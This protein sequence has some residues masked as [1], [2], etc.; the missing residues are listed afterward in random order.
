MTQPPTGAAAPWHDCPCG[1]VHPKGCHAHT[2]RDDT[3]RPCGAPA[4]TGLTV[5]YRH[6]GATPTAK[7]KAARAKT[8]IAANREVARLGMK[9]TTHP[10]E[11][12]IDLVHWTAGEVAYWRGIVVELEQQGGHEALTWG[13]TRVKEGGDD[14]GTTQEAKPHIAYLMLTQASDR[15]ASYSTA[16]LKAGVQERSIRLAEAQGVAVAGIQRAILER[17]FA[18]VLQMLRSHGIDDAEIITA[19]EQAWVEAMGVIVPEEL[20]RLTEGDRG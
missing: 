10:A 4:T 6:G 1:H 20:R 14:A 9:I 7:A 3:R 17:M 2:T 8:E 13:T 19:L 18:A 5:C 11:A 15:L 16:A 12:L